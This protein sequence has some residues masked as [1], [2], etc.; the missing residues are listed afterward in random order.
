MLFIKSKY[1]TFHFE[2]ISETQ[3]KLKKFPDT[4]A[5][6]RPMNEKQS[7]F[8]FQDLVKRITSKPFSK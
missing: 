3:P 5:A 6:F 4:L 8:R 2:K 7:P 1:I